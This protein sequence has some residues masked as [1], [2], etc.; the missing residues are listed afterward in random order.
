MIIITLIFAIFGYERLDLFAG[1]TI[2]V[3]VYSIFDN[4]MPPKEVSN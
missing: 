4:Y 2:G 1:A 3:I